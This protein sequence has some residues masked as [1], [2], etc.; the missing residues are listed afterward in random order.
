MKKIIALL[1]CSFL[2]FA[3]SAC[4]GNPDR[5]EKEDVPADPSVSADEPEERKDDIVILFTNDVHCAAE[6]NI[7]Y[8]GLAAYKKEIAEKTPFV[9]LVDCGDAIQGAYIGTVSDGEIPVRLMNEVG[10]DFAILGNHEFDYGMDRLSELIGLANAEY[11]CCN[12][13]YSGSGKTPLTQTRPY[14]V[15][16]Y[17]TTKVGFVGVSTPDSLFTSTPIRFQ[18]NGKTV[19]SFC[20]ETDELLFSTVQKTVDACRAEGAD[21]VILLAHFGLDEEASVSS[22]DL[23]RATS[24]VDAVL[25]GHSHTEIPTEVVQNRN[26]E[27]VLIAQTGTKLKNIGQLVI[28]PTGFLSVGFLSGYEKKDPGTEEV[29]RSCNADMEEQMK[30]VVATLDHDML[31]SDEDGIRMVRSREIPIGDL[32]SDAYRFATGADIAFINGGGVRAD[33]RAG[34]ITYSDLINVNPFGNHICSVEVSGQDILDMVEYFYSAVDSV[35]KKDGKAFGEHGSFGHFS[36]LRCTVHTDIPTSVI[37]ENNGETLVGVGKI[38]RVSDVMVLKDGEYVP[39]DPESTYSFAA[40]DYMI[41]S[42]GS[43]MGIL[44]AD[45]KILLDSIGTDYQI[46]TDFI[47]SLNNDFSAYEA[48]DGRVKIEP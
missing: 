32:V 7:G 11:L 48:P 46:L 9:T 36:G 23:A 22:R 3:A 37:T 24:G 8:A 39:I 42:G 41:K 45:H 33:L 29:I 1:L 15:V 5:S 16:T 19:Y 10:Y 38:R 20:G 4:S 17:G 44:L 47:K 13:T 2:L 35:Y 26:G 12:V 27:D 14:A 6:D 40:T 25:D 43:G 28:S 18:E 34:E 31:I 21:Y 30:T